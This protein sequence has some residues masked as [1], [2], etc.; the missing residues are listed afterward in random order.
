MADSR[1]DRDELMNNVSVFSHARSLK[2]DFEQQPFIYE[3]RVWCA[4]KL[5]EV[6]VRDYAREKD[7]FFLMEEIQWD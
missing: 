2:H 3:W 4:V 1:D 7:F 5:P 6:Q